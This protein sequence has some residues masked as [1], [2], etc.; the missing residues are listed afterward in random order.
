MRAGEPAKCAGAHLL[1]FI[2]GPVGCFLEAFILGLNL[3]NLADGFA[4]E[5]ANAVQGAVAHVSAGSG[6]ED[7]GHGVATGAIEGAGAADQKEPD[8]G[9]NRHRHR[10]KGFA[11]LRQCG[12]F[13]V[14]DVNQRHDDIGRHA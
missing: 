13:A 3:A 6:K 9:N 2:V 8:R 1:G 10:L 12:C 11:R 14:V 5:K 7:G 4:S